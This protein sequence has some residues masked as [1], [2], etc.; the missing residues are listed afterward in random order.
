MDSVWYKHCVCFAP[1][2]SAVRRERNVVVCLPSLLKYF[3]SL[4]EKERERWIDGTMDYLTGLYSCTNGCTNLG[5]MCMCVLLVI[6]LLFFSRNVFVLE[7]MSITLTGLY[8]T[9]SSSTRQT[10]K[11]LSLNLSFFCMELCAFVV[12]YLFV[13]V[14]CSLWKKRDRGQ[15]QTCLKYS[16]FATG[17]FESL[18]C[19]S[20]I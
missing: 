3:S 17:L 19:L 12:I 18:K 5:R 9:L 4:V 13:C 14:C 16:H 20:N 15:S 11:G 10:N 1:K 6:F 2:L 7:Q 8:F